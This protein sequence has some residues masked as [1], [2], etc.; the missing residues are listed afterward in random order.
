[1]NKVI[2]LLTT[3]LLCGPVFSQ[4]NISITGQI[5]DANGNILTHADI[6][7][8]TA[9]ENEH[10]LAFTIV[11]SKGKFT[12]EYTTELPKLTVKVNQMGFKKKK[13]LLEV[14][15]DKEFY[16][17]IFVMDEKMEALQ[18]VEVKAK[19]RVRI[20]KDTTIFN[21]QNI[22]N[23]TEQVVE[24]I[25]KKLPGMEI[26]GDGLFKFKGKDVITMLLEDDDLFG[27]AYT[28]GSKNIK[29]EDIKGIE[30]IE[31]Y[32]RN[33][34]TQG[35]EISDKVAVRLRFKKGVSIA[36][37]MELGY[38]HKERYYA[39]H[40]GIVI[41]KM[42]KAY[43]Q[44]SYNNLG[45]NVGANHFN[46][47]G[48]LMLLGAGSGTSGTKTN[49]FLESSSVNSLFKAQQSDQ[50]SN[51]F[52]SLNLVPHITK[53]LKIR[54]NLNFFN[55]RSLQEQS[56]KSIITTDSDNLIV[57]EQQDK[58]RYKPRYF[59]ADVHLENYF[60][61][62]SL[63]NTLQ[64]TRLKNTNSQAG[65]INGADQELSSRSKEFYLYNSTKLVRR[66]ND[67]NVLKLQATFAFNETP[68]KLYVMPG[69][70]FDNNSLENSVSNFQNINSKKE[71]AKLSG[72]YYHKINNN[73]KINLKFGVDYHDKSLKS[74]L[75]QNETQERYSNK[76]D[77]R[78]LIPYLK[79]SYRLTYKDMEI[80]P[81][82]GAK[83][84]DYSYKENGGA[85][86][87]SNS[88]FLLN[89]GLSLRYKINRYH[90]LH[91]RTSRS[92]SNPEEGKLFTNF[93][94]V[95]NRSLQ[96]NQLS[97]YAITSQSFNF[98]Y[99]YRDMLNDFSAGLSFSYKDA[100]KAMQSA[101]DISQDVSYTTYF[102]SNQ[103]TKNYD[104]SGNLRKFVGVLNSTVSWRSSYGI[105]E[106]YNSVNSAALRKNESK[107]WNHNFS[108]ETNFI[109]PFIFGLGGSYGKSKYDSK[110]T[111]P[112]TNE[113]VNAHALLI[114]KPSDRFITRVNYD[115]HIPM[116]S[117]RSNYTQKLNA[118]IQFYNKTKSINF[119][120]E[121]HNLLDQKDMSFINNT[122]YAQTVSNKSLQ[123]RYFLFSVGFRI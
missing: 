104:Y 88:K 100:N 53:T 40:T 56:F 87:K 12:L 69:I 45:M 60:G 62:N 27:G 50:K 55:D 80:S 38:G 47:L 43:N 120:I 78:T 13:Q 116:L 74:E 25:I 61:K 91:T 59:N 64:Y 90:E 52:G 106:Y 98:S 4:Q 48:H 63:E 21:L 26:K 41:T 54:A 65:I 95:S 76:V 70:N 9:D 89:T 101:L 115:Y 15:P 83:L 28:I 114:Y 67:K 108:I 2:L 19:P 34:L 16:H 93:I 105:G 75:I 107:I 113:N 33:S 117:N 49:T 102:L 97:F 3:L 119:K 8:T 81:T 86:P 42:L 5:K 109:G 51:F 46:P 77:Y 32:S 10:I 36:N 111:N 79:V 23:G 39:N 22:M 99:S 68:E 66:I 7:I 17:F 94:M 37:N 82:L 118:T 103:G 18:E 92:Q 84:Y 1:M 44:F 122:D 112:I 35:V 72:Y 57:I 31:N 121:G 123:E 20:K 58:K 24:D 14:H 6:L 85:N 29:A 30:A 96:S 110:Q 11:D 71:S 73:S